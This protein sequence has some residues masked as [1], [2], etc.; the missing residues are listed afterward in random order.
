MIGTDLN[1][2][3]YWLEAGNV[4]GIPTETVYGLAGNALNDEAVLTIFRVKNRPAFDPL[5]VHADSLDKVRTLV[6]ELPPVAEQLART[7]WPGPLTLLLPKRNHVPD[8]TTSGL[9]TVAI[10][11]P[12]HPL[13]LALLQLLDFP[14]AAP[15]ANPFG[16]ISPTT[17]QHVADQLGNQVP[18]ILDGGPCLVGVESTIIGFDDDGQAVVYRLGGMAVEQLEAITGPLRVQTSSSNPQSHDTPQAPGMLTSHYAPRKPLTLLAEGQVP[19]MLGTLPDE[20]FAESVGVL[21]FSR[22]LPGI[23]EAN[24][25]V[26]AP[27]GDVL[28]A[29]RNLF[30]YLRRL[31]AL[32]VTQLYAQ[33]VPDEGLGRAVNDRL[34][35]AAA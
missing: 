25:L 8:L 2:A 34:R 1:A 18:Y 10:R 33:L 29:A 21:A 23:P 26:L 12:N 14:L 28:E 17:A 32:P 31:D 24:Q 5:I 35:R 22:T 11:I 15:S 20:Q 27:N 6:R 16:Y 3:R 7:C 13:T 4:V 30:A 19:P 9:D